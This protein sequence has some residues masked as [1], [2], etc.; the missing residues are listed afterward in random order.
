MSGTDIFHLVNTL[1]GV[2]E[3]IFLYFL[4]LFS[5]CTLVLSFSSPW[6]LFATPLLYTIPCKATLCYA[7]LA[8]VHVAEERELISFLEKPFL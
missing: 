3:H 2:S 6:L 5:L 8:C 4:S 1:F 7:L